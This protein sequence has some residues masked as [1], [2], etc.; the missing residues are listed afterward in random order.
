MS[1]GPVPN[2]LWTVVTVLATISEISDIDLFRFRS[3]TDLISYL[4]SLC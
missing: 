1:A 3:L 4:V 2:L